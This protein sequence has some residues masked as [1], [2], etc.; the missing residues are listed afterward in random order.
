[1]YRKQYVVSKV[2]N[3]AILELVDL[4]TNCKISIVD[5]P[6]LQHI[7]H[8]LRGGV[9]VLDWNT[10]HHN[11]PETRWINTVLCFDQPYKAIDIRG[12]RHEKQLPFDNETEV[13]AVLN[14]DWFANPRYS[15]AF[16]E[17]KW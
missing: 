8:F 6:R 10:D 9:G 12:I 4:D 13:V 5:H 1:M 7:R 15:K 14:E 17:I 2:I 3:G 16:Y 11:A